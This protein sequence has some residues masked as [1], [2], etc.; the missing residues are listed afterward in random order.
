MPRKI[1]ST[2]RGNPVTPRLATYMFDVGDDVYDA[3]FMI[4]VAPFHEEDF[5]GFLRTMLANPYFS[6]Y[7]RPDFADWETREH[8]PWS[9]YVLHNIG[10]YQ[11]SYHS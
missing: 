7:K 10:E 9:G 1:I 11:D 2:V 4:V 6:R 3:H 8:A 5:E